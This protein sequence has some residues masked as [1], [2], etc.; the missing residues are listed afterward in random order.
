M[1]RQGGV[2]SLVAVME[3]CRRYGRS[4]AGSITM[5][6]GLCL[7][8]LAHAL[9]GA[10]PESLHSDQGAQFPS[11]A[12]TGRLASVGIQSSRDGRGRAL[13][14]VFSERLWRSLKS[15][16]VSVKDDETPAEAIQGFAQCFGRSHE[17]RQP[18][19]RGY[20]T[21]AA[22]SFGSSV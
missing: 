3:G 19:A 1:R 6:V 14:T 7:E 12:C 13:D 20:R 9:G 10:R 22:V 2:S 8:A 17:G 5:D 11:L 4:W 21:P 18:Q 16:E 15:A